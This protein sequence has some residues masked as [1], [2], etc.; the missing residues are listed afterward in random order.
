MANE[1]ERVNLL[2]ADGSLILSLTASSTGSLNSQ[3]S[4]GT[5]IVEVDG[6]MDTACCVYDDS[7]HK[8]DQN[9]LKITKKRPKS[10]KIRVNVK[11][12]FL[13]GNQHVGCYFIDRTS[14]E[15]W[16]GIFCKAIAQ[17]WMTQALVS[18]GG[19][20]AD[21]LSHQNDSST[22]SFAGTAGEAVIGVVKKSGEV[23]DNNRVDNISSVLFGGDNFPDMSAVKKLV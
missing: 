16:T 11:N 21:A 22:S 18:V 23:S 2:R 5:V 12:N 8:T 20:V 3:G 7:D 13:P 4:E 6:E 9:C 19:F 1:P 17:S 10:Q 15:G 14:D